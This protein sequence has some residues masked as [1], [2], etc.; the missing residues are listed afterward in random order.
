MVGAGYSVDTASERVCTSG[1]ILLVPEK[2]PS[3][4]ATSPPVSLG[5]KFTQREMSILRLVAL[6]FTNVQIGEKLHISKYTVAQH[7]AKALRRLGAANRT[8]LVNR[9]Y[10]E[11]ILQSHA[12]GELHDHRPVTRRPLGSCQPREHW[13]ARE[14]SRA[15]GWPSGCLD[16]TAAVR[17]RVQWR[18]RQPGARAPAGRPQ[19]PRPAVRTGNRQ[20]QAG[21]GCAHVAGARLP[22]AEVPQ[23]HDVPGRGKAQH[24]CGS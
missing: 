3:T 2:M 15:R 12:S 19:A 6:G 14:P 13:K 10:I 7:I 18:A 8:D 1:G 20:G 24:Q 21:L 9:A 5:V 16:T 11:G 23:P 4:V 22:V 17:V